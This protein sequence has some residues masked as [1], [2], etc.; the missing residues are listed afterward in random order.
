MGTRG[1]GSLTAFWDRD[2]ESVLFLGKSTGTQK[3]LLAVQFSDPLHKIKSSF[4]KK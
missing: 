4:M 2:F 1:L 3:L